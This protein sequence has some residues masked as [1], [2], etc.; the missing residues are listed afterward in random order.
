MRSTSRFHLYPAYAH[1]LTRCTSNNS[2]NGANGNLPLGLLDRTGLSS[3]TS[4][5]YS[6]YLCSKNSYNN[7]YMLKFNRPRNYTATPLSVYLED[8]S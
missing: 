4:S 7:T 2:S 6:F 8:K 3:T 5:H 1:D